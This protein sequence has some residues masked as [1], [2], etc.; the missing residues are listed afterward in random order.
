M[1]IILALVTPL[2]QVLDMLLALGLL[3]FM[4]MVAIVLTNDLR[5][6][7]RGLLLGKCVKGT[8]SVSSL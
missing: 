1:N 7:S 5:S 4:D 2:A 8:A 3:R 6:S